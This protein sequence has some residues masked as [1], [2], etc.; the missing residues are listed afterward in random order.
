M[1]E[2][3]CSR[4]EKLLVELGQCLQAPR[5]RNDLTTCRIYD[6]KA[7]PS[8]VITPGGLPPDIDPKLEI[9]SSL[10]K[11]TSPNQQERFAQ[12]PIYNSL[13]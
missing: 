12:T 7:K 2:S 3:V 6:P 8:H 1:K 9:P 4:E 11:I 5:G 13:T 10:P